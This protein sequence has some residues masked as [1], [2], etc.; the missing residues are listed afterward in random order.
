MDDRGTSNFLPHTALGLAKN[1]QFL[2]SKAW[3]LSSNHYRKNNI[4]LEVNIPKMILLIK[5]HCNFRKMRIHRPWIALSSKGW[6]KSCK[7]NPHWIITISVSN[8]S[9]VL[10]ERVG[11]GGIYIFSLPISCSIHIYEYQNT[12][13]I[14]NRWIAPGAIV[15]VT[16]IMRPP[17]NS[18]TNEVIIIF[19]NCLSSI[20]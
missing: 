13:H 1:L 19:S 14:Y 3:E 15:V 16:L 18:S 8:L 2:T 10:N 4:R 20:Y 7:A 11:V 9:R 6:D 17:I 12:N 5:I